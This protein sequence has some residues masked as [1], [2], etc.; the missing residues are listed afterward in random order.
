MYPFIE[1]KSTDE[2]VFFTIPSFEQTNLVKHGFSSKIGGVSQG[3]YASLNLGFKTE[4]SNEKVENNYKKIA[5]ALDISIENLVFSDQVHKD[6]IKIVTKK[7]CG[8]GIIKESD[9]KEIDALITNETNVALATVYADCVPIF[10]LD[11]VK[12]V[13][14]LAHAGWRGTVLKIGKKTVEKMINVYET[15]PKDCLAA[16]GP[17]I[18]KCCY[19][20]DENVIKE[21][22]KD[23]TNLNKFVFSKGNG[24]YMLDLWKANQIT[25]KEIGLLER[26]I[27]ISNM[28]TMCHSEKFFSYRRDQGITGRMAAIIELK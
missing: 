27:S 18:G 7:D 26:N 13:I 11:P 10:L 16:I 9:I 22:N 17:S 5:K 15:N 12:K 8:K 28:C 6:H 19:E 25:L 3:K 24:K 20:V 2:V 14:A 23:F 21:F 1:N 4:D